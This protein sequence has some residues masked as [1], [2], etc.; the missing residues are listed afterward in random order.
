M[1]VNG[2]NLKS[3]NFYLWTI[4]LQFK[5]IEIG[6]NRIL[7]NPVEADEGFNSL[8]NF[9]PPVVDIFNPNGISFNLTKA[10]HI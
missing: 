7:I 2:R 5:H 1:N 3:H 8:A 6:S 10:I 4:S 9:Q